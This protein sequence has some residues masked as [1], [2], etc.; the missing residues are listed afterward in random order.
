MKQSIRHKF[1][2]LLLLNENAIMIKLSFTYSDVIISALVIL[3]EN[4][5]SGLPS[6]PQHKIA[7]KQCR[8]YSG[9]MSFYI[10]GGEPEARMFLKSLKVQFLILLAEPSCMTL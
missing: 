6:H 2:K 9:M 8:G 5:F 7:K 3:I 1:F 10:T 4:S